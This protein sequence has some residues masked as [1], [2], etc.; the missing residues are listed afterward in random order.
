V[1]YSSTVTV[2]FVEL[3]DA[4]DAALEAALSLL[5][6]LPQGAREVEDAPIPVT[7]LF[8]ISITQKENV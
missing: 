6:D 2:H 4:Q 7:E 3:D 5:L 8:G 1:N